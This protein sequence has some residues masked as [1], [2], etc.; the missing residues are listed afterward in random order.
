MTSNR[1]AISTATAA[2][3]ASLLLLAACGQPPAPVVMGGA[4]A[5][6]TP[7]PRPTAKPQAPAAVESSPTAVPLPRPKPAPSPPVTDEAVAVAGTVRVQAGD[8]VYALSRRHHVGVRDIIAANGLKPPYKLAIGQTL[9]LPRAR[10]HT[11]RAGETLY[12]LSGFY[13]VDMS[14][15]VRANDIPAPYRLVVGQRLRL[16]GAAPQIAQAPVE[17]APATPKKKRPRKGL[18]AT[19]PPRAGKYFLWPAEGRLLSSFGPKQGGLHNDGI[20]FAVPRGAPLR[21]AENGVVAY[22]GNELPG[23]GNLL[24]IRHDGGWMSAYAHNETLLVTRGDEVKRGQIVSRAG[25]TGNVAS[26]Q[27]HFELRRN[28]KPVNPVKYLAKL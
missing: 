16:P 22:A 3:A 12:G 26:P 8:T 24:L 2:L 20:N 28:G 18:P 15:L 23:Y 27:A 19:P 1:R 25:S 13:R 17:T 7:P 6:Q 21:A 4:G 10:Y 9:G 5:E 11:V 14:A